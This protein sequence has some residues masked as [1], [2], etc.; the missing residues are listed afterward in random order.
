[1]VR[2]D[3][4]YLPINRGFKYLEN[5]VTLIIKGDTGAYSVYYSN[6]KRCVNKQ[7]LNGFTFNVSKIISDLN[8]AGS[9]GNPYIPTSSFVKN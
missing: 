4:D 8:N 7:K 2:I 6:L 3:I 5:Y 1:M 9:K